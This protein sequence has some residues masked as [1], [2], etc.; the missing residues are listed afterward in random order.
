MAEYDLNRIYEWPKP[1][2]IFLTGL[3]FVLV[4]YFGYAFDI[5]SL[6][7]Q[8]DALKKQEQDLLDQYKSSVNNQTIIQAHIEQLPKLKL[9]LNQLDKNLT[10]PSDITDLLDKILQM[11][12]SN[13]LQFS[14]FEPG[15]KIQDGP[16]YKIPIKIVMTGNYD[17]TGSF[18]SQVANMK[19]IVKIA[20]F[21]ISTLPNEIQDATSPDQTSTS[22]NTALRLKTD[23]TLEVY[24]Q[25]K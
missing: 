12:A 25:L 7:K 13:A 23:L 19:N 20:D 10:K 1:A 11:G 6:T 14:L 5:A 2:K 22:L 17:Q 15:S 24:E 21:T 8:T 3:T 16:F 4:L 9:I 18:I